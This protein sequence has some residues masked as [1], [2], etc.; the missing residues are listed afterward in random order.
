MLK[1]IAM[2]YKKSL[3]AIF[4]I[5]SAVINLS[6]QILKGK[7]T[8]SEGNPVPF[9]TVYIS[10]IKHGTTANIKG[11]YLINLN[12]GT[13]TIF[14][15]SLGFSPDSRRVL[16]ENEDKIID[17]MLQVQFYEIPEVR[18]T[19]SGEDPAYAIM[20]KAIALAPYYLNQIKHY[21]AEV[22][23]KGSVIVR[24]IPN[25]IKRQIEVNNESI[26]EGEVYL[27]ESINEIEFDAPDRYNQ[28]II[29][30]HSTFPESEMGGDISPM[31]V[32]QASFY[33]PL[34]ADIAISPL[35]PNAMSHYKFRYDGSSPQ[36]QYIVNKIAVI[37]KRKSQQVFEGTIYII[38]DYWCLHSIDLLNE[39]IAGSIS[40]K[41]VYAPVQ[42]NI[43]MPVT[44]KFSINI[45]IVG[46]KA[47]GEYGSAVTYSIVEPNTDLARP[48]DLPVAQQVEE[49]PPLED[50]KPVSR[51]QQKINELLA[52]DELNNRDMVK[53]SRLIEKEADKLDTAANELEIKDRTNFTVEDD[54]DKR[55]SAY[56]NAV[57][58]IPL[59]D[60]EIM[61][62]R[63]SDS[64]SFRRTLTKSEIK[65]DTTLVEEDTGSVAKRVFSDIAFGK[66]FSS[67]KRK[68]SFRFEGLIDPEKFTYNTVDGIRY[69]VGFRVTKRWEDGPILTITPSV[70]WAF[71]RERLLWRV[72]ASLNYNRMKQARLFIW[73]GRSSND[74]NSS[75]GISPMLNS[76]TSLFFRDNWL[77][78]Y[79]S[80]FITVGH[81]NEIVNGLY[82][83]FRYNYEDRRMLENNS[84]YSFLSKDQQFTPNIPVNDYLPDPPDPGA[85][86]NLNNHIHQE[87]SVSLSY[88]PR[89]KYYINNGAKSPAGS[90]FPTFRLLWE[91]GVNSQTGGDALSYDLI[92]ADASKTRSIGAFSEYGWSVGAGAYVNNEGI[93]FP[94]FAHFNSQPLPVL[95]TNYRNVFMIPEYYSLATPEYYGEV[96]F[97]YTTPYLLIKLLPFLSNTLMR[98]NISLAYLYTPNTSNYWEVGYALSEIFFIGRAGIYAGF[99]DFTFKGAAVRFTFIFE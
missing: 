12:P 85:E 18:V 64:I 28:K 58:P 31:D 26:R 14:F 34:I 37:P 92:K 84:D 49:P 6:G 81:R 22:Y 94:D 70:D 87:G 97:R 93:E 71:A 53:L 32:V 74:F 89:Q 52:K 24:N 47:D 4:F 80:N 43:W 40:I 20:R 16:I 3:L 25:I 8:N 44:H 75:A 39:N 7:I 59:S 83:E 42:D 73:A 78:L 65:N 50:N 10:E 27:I 15:Q 56:W 2:T 33:Q 54:A 91:H 99:E 21:Q 67:E 45:S 77:K 90:S 55:D 76:I 13:Y 79:E 82:V 17:V 9:A 35:A 51:E 48:A 95:L 1:A 57:R 88:T 69:G 66:T 29:S 60:E 5:V 96:H 19:S 86:Y 30:Q 36:G 61:S 46:V 38:E 41:Q 11:E 63:V 72:N 62:I 23:I 68:L 98:E